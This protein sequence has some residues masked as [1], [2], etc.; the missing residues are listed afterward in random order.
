MK[1]P[2]VVKLVSKNGYLVELKKA[3]INYGFFKVIVDS[4]E[5]EI[6]LLLHEFDESWMRYAIGKGSDTE[7]IRL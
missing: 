7:I 5:W 1:L 6:T 4:P 2:K 3:K